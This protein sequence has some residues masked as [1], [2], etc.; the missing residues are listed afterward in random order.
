ME[1][2]RSRVPGRAAD[3][4]WRGRER[5][6]CRPRPRARDREV[7]VDEEEAAELWCS[8]S[9]SSSARRRTAWA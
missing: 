2:T 5:A 9:R 8:M 1:E 3:F 7:M 4:R 6:E